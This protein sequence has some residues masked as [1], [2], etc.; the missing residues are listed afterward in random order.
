MNDTSNSIEIE[1]KFIIPGTLAEAA[2]VNCL[3][4][5]KYRIDKITPL[6]NI[7]IYMD[8]TDW[9]LLKNKLSLRYRLSNSTAMYTLK[10]VSAIEDGI[11][12]RMETELVLKK[13]A[14]PPTDIPIKTLRK[15]VNEVIY[16][17]KLMEQILIRTNRHRYLVESPEGA[18]FEL[19]FDTSSF[20]ADALFRPKR[21][22]LVHQLEAEI[23]EG[24]E[25]ALES[26]AKLIS[27]TFHYS[28][29]T[30]TKLEIAITQLKIEPL[31][32]KV[33]ENLKVKLDDRLD[34][35]LKKILAVEFR[36]LEEQLSGVISDRDPEFVHQ[37][38]VATRRMRSALIL[39]H[40]AIPEAT[41]IYFEDRLKWLGGLFGEVRDLDVFI[42][43]LTGYKGMIESFSK[44]K[45]KTLES[46]V[47]KQ[48]RIPLK[49][50]SD[51]LKS[52]RFKNFETRMTK[53]LAEPCMDCQEL[54]TAMKPIREVAPP[55]ITQKFDNVLEQSKKALSNP[56]LNEFHALRIQMK[57]LR[58][59]FEFLAPPYGGAFDEVIHRTVEIQD[60]L[61]ELQDT[62]FNQKLITH[63]L[64]DWE[65]KLVDADLIFI[66][67]EIYQYQGEI[68][69]E[70][71]KTFKQLWEHFC[72]EKPS[73]L[74]NQV[75]QNQEK[76]D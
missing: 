74:F 13:P 66:L 75:L 72:S 22:S 67:G 59:T 43:N 35:A 12:K 49:A 2:V 54:P 68:A 46:L 16:P 39:F 60:C 10:S 8:T 51:A 14:H 15:Q 55:M 11:A 26:M 61:G 4:Q 34:T 56:K 37:A 5:N 40:N 50:L 9:A 32:K 7:D 21:A 62:V 27:D 57:R 6:K 38:R 24:S 58:Y 42:I 63:I 73:A 30:Q 44:K 1:L 45:R 29:A 20:A 47:V 18:R 53:F 28:K 52:R 64:E 3:R 71:Q 23:I 76:A 36:W 31:I 69:R 65:G 25:A 48:R 19:S 41:A 17:R 33:P 70:R